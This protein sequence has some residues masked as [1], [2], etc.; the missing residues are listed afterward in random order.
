MYE[1]KLEENEADLALSDSSK[2]NNVDKIIEKWFLLQKTIKEELT[3]EEV[4]SKQ[5]KNDFEQLKRYFK[6]YY[7]NKL[8]IRRIL[9]E[10]K[11]IENNNKNNIRTLN[12][13]RELEHV[14]L[15]I[16]EPIKNLLFLFRNNY[17]YIITLISLITEYD[18]EEKVSSLVE[19]FCNQF[20]ENI[21]VKNSETEELIILIYKLLEKEVVP[22]NFA[23]IDEFLSDDTF[24]GK[25]ISS[26]LKR[27]ELKHFLSSLI[28]PFILNIENSKGD[29]YCGMSLVKINEFVKE[30]INEGSLKKE[31]M[32]NNFSIEKILFEKINKSSIN[33][34]KV[35]EDDDID[36]EEEIE[37]NIFEGWI[38][39]FE[40]D[41][42]IKNYND[43]YKI[44]LDLDYL[45]E[46]I[47]K[48]N[49][50]ELKNFYSYEIEQITNDPN[51]F[52]NIN[53]LELFKENEFNENL[54]NVV[55]IYKENFIFLKNTV[56]YF[57]QL[58]IDQVEMVPYTLRCICKVISILLKQKFPSLLN[59][60]RNSFI[61][62]FIFDKCIFPVLCLENKNILE[63]R[64]L[65]KN[66]KS[67][68]IDIVSILNH[69]N[70]CLL[71]NSELDSEKTIFNHYLIEII[72][73]LNKFYEKLIDVDLPPVLDNLLF[74]T[75]KKISEYKKNINFKKRKSSIVNEDYDLTE[76]SMDK[77]KKPLYNY[78]DEHK[79]EILNLQ[80]ICFSL[81]D[82]LFILSLIGR[83]MKAFKNLP[84]YLF[85]E[86]TYEFIQ[87][88]DYKLDQE[89]SKN[90]DVKNLFII[91]QDEKNTELK[92]FMKG[93]KNQI[94]AFSS[95]QEDSLDVIKKFKFCIKKVLT[96]MKFL[97]RKDYAYLNIANTSKQFFKALKYILEEHGEFSEIK[98]RIPLKWYGEY[99]YNNRDNLDDKYKL[100]D[101]LEIYNEIYKEESDSLNKLKSLISILITRNRINL[102][103]AE[104]TLEIT[105]KELIHIQQI[106]E[107]VKVEKFINEE[108]IEVCIQTNELQNLRS[109]E[110]KRSFTMSMLFKK[111]KEIEAHEVKQLKMPLLITD[112]LNLNCPHNSLKAND[113]SE[114]ESNE[115]K[116]PYHAYNIKDFI[117]KFSEVPWKE[118]KLVKYEKPK[119]LVIDDIIKGNNNN[120]IYR[121]IN[122]YMEIIRKHLMEPINLQ[123]IFEQLK[124]EDQDR[125]LEKIKDYLIRQ[126][127]KFIFPIEP[128]GDDFNF[129]NKVKRLKWIK[130]KHLSINNINIFHLSSAISWIKR[131]EFYKSIKD[132]FHCINKIYTDL[133]NAINFD[134]GIKNAKKEELKPL[135]LY[136]I[137]KA[138]PQRML[139]N[140]NY[141]KC[142][143]DDIEIDE[144]I[145]QLLTLLESSKEFVLNISYQFLN[146]TQEEFDKNYNNI[147]N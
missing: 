13:D 79:E 93:K 135:F 67:C 44:M 134:N 146:I 140:L 100:N 65:S 8:N 118:D 119:N 32:T 144:K 80:C 27:Y 89:N 101:Y 42:K 143:T 50:I 98:N 36:I 49:N 105:N 2:Q 17:D 94:L 51:I 23:S 95:E 46:K 128:L 14:F 53:I 7:K 120:Q 34:D 62:K 59:Y 45:D 31:K 97:N 131:F 41:L 3:L 83:N 106:K 10:I 6:E 139:S 126:I 124:D 123:Q 61:G 102:C 74:D 39:K 138:Q 25:F 136:I 56:D 121:T 103:C 20:Y 92:N 58:L 110:K 78:F 81:D 132:K 142:F 109:S 88:S 19:L 71:F 108:E 4:I 37:Q 90:P 12:M 116:I 18:E 1:I 66:T 21:L 77:E 11:A 115:N 30:K 9:E 137:I 63:P 85:F 70:K 125:I 117:S 54:I 40:D 22:M 99:M 26:F 15:D 5:Q 145:A 112:D 75:R 43:N 76:K 29:D 82:I 35:D 47:N 104:N 84:D 16:S 87:P 48:E 69:A 28:N 107:N 55:N 141:I 96:G 24:L 38:K 60:V 57:I 122:I 130:P 147:N 52:S 73:L 72:P 91:F 114:T 33:F 133:T 127:Y 86:R 113:T 64:I 129:Y 68:L 111:D